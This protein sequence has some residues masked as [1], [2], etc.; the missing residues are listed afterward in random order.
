MRIVE[1]FV[2][3][4][5]FVMEYPPAT[6]KALMKKIQA[7]CEPRGGPLAVEFRSAEMFAPRIQESI[8]AE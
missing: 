6:V 3:R 7:L 5:P 2:W 1:V 8:N 4:G